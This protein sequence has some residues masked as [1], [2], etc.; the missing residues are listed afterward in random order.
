M[1][2]KNLAQLKRSLQKGCRYKVIEHY[3]KP[4]LAGVREVNV[5]QTNGIYTKFPD[6]PSDAMENTCNSGKGYWMEFGKAKDWVFEN[7]T[8][9]LTSTYNGETKPILKMVVLQ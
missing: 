5:V 2:I 4:N 9:L 6:K 8:C 3:I 1:E 7:E